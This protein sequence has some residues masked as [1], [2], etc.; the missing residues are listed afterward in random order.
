MNNKDLQE[1]ILERLIQTLSFSV[2]C[3]DLICP[4]SLL[5]PIVRED[6]KYLT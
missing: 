3:L 5:Y 6:Q 4:F 1:G 2:Q